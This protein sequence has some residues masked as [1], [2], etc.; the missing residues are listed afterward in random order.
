[1]IAASPVD[2]PAVVMVDTDLDSAAPTFAVL[3]PPRELG[4]GDLSLIPGQDAAS[5]LA[6]V[7]ALAA[8]VAPALR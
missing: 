7:E 2:E 4:V 8:E 5:S 1:M 6:T 3:R